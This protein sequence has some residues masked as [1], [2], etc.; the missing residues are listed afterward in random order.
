VRRLGPGDRRE[1]RQ[2]GIG[3]ALLIAVLFGGLVPWLAGHPPPRWPWLVAALLLP[4]AAL[5][6]VAVYPVYRVLYPLLRALTALNNAL[7][8]GAVYFLLLWPLGLLL[9]GA[10]R[11]HYRTGF[12]PAA[13]SYRVPV[14]PAHSTDL[15]EPF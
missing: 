6:P 2:F 12:D 9:R 15:E 10:A 14:D 7:L 8:L 3:L 11:L 5:V 4:V 13:R 1:L